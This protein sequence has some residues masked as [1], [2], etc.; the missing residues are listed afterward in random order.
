ME[1]SLPLDSGKGGLKVILNTLRHRISL[2]TKQK[3]GG[4]DGGLEV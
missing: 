2:F 4:G 3:G 1:V